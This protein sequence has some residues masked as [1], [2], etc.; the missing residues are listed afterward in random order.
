MATKYLDY[1]GLEHI[2]G[3]L[4]NRDFNGQGLSHED[5]TAE[6]KIQLAGLYT[7]LKDFDPSGVASDTNLTNL[8]NKVDG[9]VAIINNEGA[10]DGDKIINKLN[11]VFAFL[12]DLSSDD[13]LAAILSGKVNTEAGKGLSSND[14]TDSEKADVAKIAAIQTEVGKKVSKDEISSITNAEIDALINTEV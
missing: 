2:I 5:F 10:E 14:Y 9:L 6:L 13:K 8:Q 7:K 12:S 4:K 1:A 11:E 3:K